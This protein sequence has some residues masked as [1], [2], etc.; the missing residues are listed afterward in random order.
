MGKTPHGGQ[1]VFRLIV[2][3]INSNA[4]VERAEARQVGAPGMAAGI[5]EKKRI[6]PIVL[7]DMLTGLRHHL[8]G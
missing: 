3:H 7:K 6:K 4:L 2:A 8:G 5:I 1:S